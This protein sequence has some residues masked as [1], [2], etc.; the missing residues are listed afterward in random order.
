[1]SAPVFQ[2]NVDTPAFEFKPAV[3][4]PVPSQEIGKTKQPSNKSEEISITPTAKEQ[5]TP[6]KKSEEQTAFDKLSDN[7]VELSKIKT[8][9]LKDKKVS[10]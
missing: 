6:K 2:F 7:I 1:M 5:L 8:E 4:S 9:V 10:A 3:S